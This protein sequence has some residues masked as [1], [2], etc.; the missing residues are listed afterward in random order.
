MHNLQ[1]IISLQDLLYLVAHVELQ[2]ARSVSVSVLCRIQKENVLFVP[3]F[4]VF[5]ATDSI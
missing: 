4:G 2:R 1:A 3:I 5:K